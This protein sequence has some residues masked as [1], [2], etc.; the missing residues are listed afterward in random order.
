MDQ[1]CTDLCLHCVCEKEEVYLPLNNS[2]NANVNNYTSNNTDSNHRF[3]ISHYQCGSR[4]NLS[5]WDFRF[6]QW[7]LFVTVTNINQLEKTEISEAVITIVYNFT[8]SL[9]PKF[10]NSR[11][12]NVY[13][14]VLRIVLMQSG[15]YLGEG[16]PQ[17]CLSLSRDDLLY[18]YSS[19]NS[20]NV[21]ICLP[22]VAY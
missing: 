21:R 10:K 15:T 13:N 6:C 5:Y 3:Q 16:I 20:P 8:Q 12:I 11:L 17:Y 1:F 14:D 9:R 18:F 7:L 22:C 4:Y 19:V 2:H